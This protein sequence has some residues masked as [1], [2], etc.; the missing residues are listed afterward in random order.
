ML[1]YS[2]LVDAR[3]VLLEILQDR[4]KDLKVRAGLVLGLAHDMERYFRKSERGLVY[5]A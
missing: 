1:L 2:Q 5:I 3:E 4:T